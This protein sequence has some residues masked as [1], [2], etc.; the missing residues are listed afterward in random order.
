[1]TVR[2][3]ELLRLALGAAALPALPRSARAETFPSRPITMIVPASAGGPTDTIG[4]MLLERMQAAL[5]QT[6]VVENVGGAGG[7]IATTRVARATP[8][9]YTICIGGWNH[10]VVNG[11]VYPLPY[12][13]HNDFQ[14]IAMVAAGP[15]LILS[16]KDIPAGNLQELIAWLKTNGEKTMAGTGGLA[17]PPHIS[18]LKFQSQ[19]GTRFQFVPYRGA[20]PAMQDLIAGHID[21]MFDQASSTLAQVQSGT[22]KAYA[23]TAKT[24][25]A[26]APDIPTV[27]EA[28]LPGFYVSIWQGIFAPK[29]VPGDIVAKID[30]AVVAALADPGVQK[31]LADIGQEI[32]ARELQSPGGFSAFHKAEIE[33]W[34]PVIKAADIKME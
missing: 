21:I 1:M 10:F 18:G 19:T 23:V 24:R 12:D 32:P 15:Q 34:W 4:R 17:S 11:A 25:L 8:D 29:S 20:N 28:G 2:R 5:G 22:L 33:K 16:R 26:S 27:D 6:I 31:R 13:L 7:T 9:G 30:A 3:R 14:P